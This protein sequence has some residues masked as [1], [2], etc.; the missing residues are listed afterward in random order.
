M[1]CH[2]FSDFSEPFWAGDFLFKSIEGI[3]TSPIRIFVLF[4]VYIPV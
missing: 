3:V 1:T 4:E 2:K